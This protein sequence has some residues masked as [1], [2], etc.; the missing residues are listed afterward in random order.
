MTTRRSLLSVLAV[1]GLAL[2][3]WFT[4]SPGVPKVY[5][6]LNL[7]VV[8]PAWLTSSS[9][10]ATLVALLLF[11]ALFCL[12]CWPVLRGSAKLPTRSIALLI[13][14]VALSAGRLVLGYRYGVEH[15]G[16][17]YVAGVAIINLLC[18]AV[19]GVLG[20]LARRRP[21]FGCNFAFHVALFGW[22]AWGAFPYL[23]ELP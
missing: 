6:P 16:T 9:V 23:G 22:L 13:C 2:L 15:E 20:V 21:S 19:L 7:L 11:P 17:G 12:W 8:A 1:V 14:A 18:W 10:G 3:S 5:A 4:I